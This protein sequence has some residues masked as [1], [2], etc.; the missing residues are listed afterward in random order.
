MLPG[1]FK[2]SQRSSY[3]YFTFQNWFNTQ[4]GCQKMCE[5]VKVHLNLHFL[6]LQYLWLDAVF[7]GANA[8]SCRFPHSV[9][10]AG[11]SLLDYQVME[12]G[13]WMDKL[14]S[15]SQCPLIHAGWSCLYTVLLPQKTA[16]LFT[17]IWQALMVEACSPHCLCSVVKIS[18]LICFFS[19]PK[20]LCPT[21]SL[22]TS[23]LIYWGMQNL[24]DALTLNTACR[25]PWDLSH[26]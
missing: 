26:S 23:L 9:S 11:R 10:S 1:D 12:L 8:V 13:L 2:E 5:K 21:R 20:C 15:G 18:L 24:L 19:V 4:Y 7:G 25:K 22:S 14:F 6:F 16:L 3:M 17:G